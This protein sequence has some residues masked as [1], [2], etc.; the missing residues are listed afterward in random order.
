MPE[1][2]RR[3]PDPAAGR[4]RKAVANALALGVGLTL[5]V[6]MLVWGLRQSGHAKSPNISKVVVGTN[7]MVYYSHAATEEDAGV[8]GQALKTIG[9]F[10]DRGVS[11]FLS[12]GKNG[13][14]VSFVVQEGAWDLPDRVSD[15]E[16]IG[17]RIATAVGGFPIKVR[18]ID[19]A[20]LVHREVALGKAMGGARYEVYYFD[21]AT[22][23]DA[24][25]LGAALKAAEYFTDQGT[26]V[27]LSKGGRTAISFVVND[28]A[29]ERPEIVG[30]FVRLVRRAAASVGGLPITVR[31]LDPNMEPHREAAVR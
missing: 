24:E 18:L 22:K 8:L 28:G 31:L 30:A 25:A 4:A 10:Q 9:Y 26:S 3:Q 11:V 23:A 5:L 2:P 16:E 20:Q 19:S 12:K 1:P 6:M 21:S 13:T 14:V 27:E 7:D 15:Y 17:R 29:W